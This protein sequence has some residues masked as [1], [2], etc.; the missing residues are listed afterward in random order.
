MNDNTVLNLLYFLGAVCIMF[1]MS[2]IARMTGHISGWQICGLRFAG[3]AVAAIVM[4]KALGRIF[5][6][7]D[8]ATLVDVGR[9][10]SMCVFLV[11][12]ISVLKLRTGH[13]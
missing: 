2:W 1:K 6:D 8:P 10:L 7:G 5:W 9:E 12:A 4:G 3:A 13:W 11:F